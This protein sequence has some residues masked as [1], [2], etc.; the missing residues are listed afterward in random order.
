MDIYLPARGGS[1]KRQLMVAMNQTYIVVERKRA[2]VVNNNSAG[3]ARYGWPS[4]DLKNVEGWRIRG[5]FGSKVRPRLIRL[6]SKC[7]SGPIRCKTHRIHQVRSEQ[8]RITQSKCLIQTV[9]TLSGHEQIILGDVI[10]RLPLSGVGQIPDK[11]RMTGA[12]LVIDLANSHI[13][14]L[15]KWSAI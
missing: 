12:P 6:E 13:V 7:K 11:H 2:R 3:G 9:N 15:G 4:V 14:V 1:T 10:R 5:Y 8:I